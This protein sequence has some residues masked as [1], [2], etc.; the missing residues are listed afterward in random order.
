MRSNQLVNEVFSQKDHRK[1]SYRQ[2]KLADNPPVFLF[3]GECSASNEE[4]HHK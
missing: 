1:E 4:A 2:I 3:S